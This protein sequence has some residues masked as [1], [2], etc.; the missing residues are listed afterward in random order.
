MYKPFEKL[1]TLYEV[2][3]HQTKI[4]YEYPWLKLDILMSLCEVGVIDVLILV[5]LKSKV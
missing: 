1:V 4:K 5:L 2:G 3:T